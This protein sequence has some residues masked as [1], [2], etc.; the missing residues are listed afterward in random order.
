M[1]KSYLN[2]NNI[3]VQILP[4]YYYVGTYNNTHTAELIIVRYSYIGNYSYYN[5][6]LLLRF[7]FFITN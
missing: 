2:Y 4:T 1:I 6:I 7:F 5:N 3:K